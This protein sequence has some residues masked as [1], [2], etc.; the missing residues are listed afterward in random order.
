CYESQNGEIS[1]SQSPML[2]IQ[3]GGDKLLQ[4]LVI[5]YDWVDQ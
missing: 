1:Y 5:L 4:D 2:V 3:G